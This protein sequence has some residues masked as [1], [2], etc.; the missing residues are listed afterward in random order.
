M[1]STI[2]LSLSGGEGIPYVAEGHREKNYPLRI[3][4]WEYVVFSQLECDDDIDV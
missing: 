3:I 2:A 1:L 4:I